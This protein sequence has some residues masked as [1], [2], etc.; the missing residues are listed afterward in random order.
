MVNG[1]VPALGDGL[2]YQDGHYSDQ[3]FDWRVGVETN[4]TPSHLLYATVSTGHHSGGFNDTLK[5]PSTGESITKGYKPED[6]M[7]FEIGSK[8]EILDRKARINVAVFDYEYNN[9]QFQNV[10]PLGPPPAPNTPAFSAGVR[11]NAAQSRVLGA[12]I[13]GDYQLPFGLTVKADALLLDAK[14]NGDSRVRDPRLSWSTDESQKVSIDG[15]WL[16]K[17]SRL[18]L[19]YSLGQTIKTPIGYFDWIASAQTR[20][21]Y[22]LTV[23]N[24]EGTDTK[25]VPNANL[26]DAVDTYTRVDL[27]V[28]H[29]RP[30]GKLRFEGFIN[31]LTDVWFT[32]SQITQPN[33]NL[34]FVNPPRQFGVKVTVYM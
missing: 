1:S 32:N 6:L 10:V 29:T 12:E 21:K 22:Y 3:F 23:F 19:N 24:G 26:H 8:N 18:T 25:G 2:A 13:G 7:A 27:G 34:R 4:I 20:T 33:L 16:P 30:D 17:A 31:N 5:I 28:G 14:F 9:M 11:D 15:K